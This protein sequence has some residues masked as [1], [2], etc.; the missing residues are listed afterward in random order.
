MSKQLNVHKV[1]SNLITTHWIL[2]G[3]LNSSSVDWNT[4]SSDDQLEFSILKSILK[5]NLGL[6]TNKDFFLQRDVILTDNSFYGLT[7]NPTK[8]SQINL[9]FPVK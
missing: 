3:N 7:S 5:F 1:E 8:A 6:L 9:R 4:L 2:C